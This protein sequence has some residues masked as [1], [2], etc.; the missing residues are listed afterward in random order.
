MDT[1]ETKLLETALQKLPKRILSERS[2]DEERKSERE[3]RDETEA[4]LGELMSDDES[5]GGQTNDEDLR[6][7]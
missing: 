1:R 5:E 4:E 7:L 2:I 6:K 3:L